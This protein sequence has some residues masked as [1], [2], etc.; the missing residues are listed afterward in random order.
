MQTHPGGFT[1]EENV[2]RVLARLIF[3]TTGDSFAVR[4]RLCVRVAEARP[5]WELTRHRLSELKVERRADVPIE[6][7]FEYAANGRLSLAASSPG[8]RTRPA[9]AT[10][11]FS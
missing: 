3:R 10:A 1:P 7:T 4:D 11:A 2:S 8:S 6:V 5:T 9:Q